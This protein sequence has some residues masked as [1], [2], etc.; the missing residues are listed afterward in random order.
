MLSI[1]FIRSFLLTFGCILRK[2]GGWLNQSFWRIR[3]DRRH[4]V[5]ASWQDF[6]ISPEGGDG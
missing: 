2:G 3:S 6:G 5:H 1:S 4:L